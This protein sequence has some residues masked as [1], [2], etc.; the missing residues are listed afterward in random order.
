MFPTGFS[1]YRKFSLKP[2]SSKKQNSA[3]LAQLHPSSSRPVDSHTERFNQQLY[4]ADREL[5]M[6]NQAPGGRRG[7]KAFGSP[8]Q[9]VHDIEL[10]EI[11]TRRD[12]IVST[13]PRLVASNRSIEL[14]P[15]SNVAVL[16]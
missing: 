16:E 4:D 10:D 11:F 13:G 15:N 7:T 9:V 5:G 3:A 2:T 8:Q 1:K 12:V 6:C 14:A